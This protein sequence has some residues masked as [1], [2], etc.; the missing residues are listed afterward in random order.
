M[1]LGAQNFMWASGGVDRTYMFISSYATCP[2]APVGAGLKVEQVGLE[3][4]FYHG[5]PA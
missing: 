5:M 2:G 4:A 3:L 1:K